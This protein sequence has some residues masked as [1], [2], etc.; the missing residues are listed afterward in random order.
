M[1]RVSSSCPYYLLGA[2]ILEE[3]RNPGLDKGVVCLRLDKLAGDFDAFVD[4]A[5]IFGL[6]EREAA[7]IWN[8]RKHEAL[9]QS[10]PCPHPCPEEI[11]QGLYGE[12]GCR[13]LFNLACLL[14]LPPCSGPCTV[15]S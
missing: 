1:K 2:C 15:N 9:K 14:R 6:E 13:Y 11:G 4:R 7:R 8:A 10:F 12:L 5:E 3:T